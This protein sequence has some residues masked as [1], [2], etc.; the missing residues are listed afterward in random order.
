M[1]FKLKSGNSPMFNRL[2]E[3]K[4]TPEQYNA[5]VRAE[6][7]AKLQAHSDSTASYNKAV[8]VDDLYKRGQDIKNQSTQ[9]LFNTFPQERENEEAVDRSVREAGDLRAQVTEIS[10]KDT[11]EKLINPNLIQDRDGYFRDEYGRY[12]QE[13]E[14]TKKLL[15]KNYQKQRE[16]EEEYLQ[17]KQKYVSE[18]KTSREKFVEG[19]KKGGKVIKEGKVLEDELKKGEIYPTEKKKLVKTG[20]VEFTYTTTADQVKPGPPPIEPMEMLDRMKIKNIDMGTTPDVIEPSKRKYMTSADGKWKINL[21]TGEKTK[22]KTQKVKRTFR[23]GKRSVKNLVTG[24][25]NRVQ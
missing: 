16:K 5:R 12:Y 15:R 9:G 20:D 24:G 18:A 10:N 19:H 4:E 3:E 7:E 23:P 2:G 25:T 21:E 1:A 22:V 8:V 17:N 6:Y 13:T 14:E 11:E